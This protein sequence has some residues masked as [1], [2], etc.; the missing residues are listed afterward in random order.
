M[1]QIYNADILGLKHQ[2]SRMANLLESAVESIIRCNIPY[3]VILA[4]TVHQ[5]IDFDQS[6]QNASYPINQWEAS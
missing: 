1:D 4:T 3:R 6:L 2:R 5:L